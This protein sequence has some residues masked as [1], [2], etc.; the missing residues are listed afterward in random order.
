MARP[1]KV[2]NWLTEDGLSL[3]THWRRNNLRDEDIAKKI[4]IRRQTLSEWKKR[5]PDID[6][7]LKKGL[8]YCISDAEE[9]LISK[10][11][12]VEYEEVRKEQWL[13]PSGKY[14]P[15]GEPIMTIREQH[16]VSVKKTNQPDT[17]AIIFFLKAKAGWRDNAEITDT[18]AISKLDAILKATQEQ[19][20]AEEPDAALSETAAIL[21]KC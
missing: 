6:G 20:E 21:P 13:V 2:A 10:F 12:P 4:G 14:K 5:Y 11:K 17:T 9:A 19:A 8:E 16:I 15:N 3:L 1:S 7:A 18:T